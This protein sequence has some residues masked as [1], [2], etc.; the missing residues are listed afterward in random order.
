MVLSDVE[1]VD[2][3]ACPYRMARRFNIEQASA[4]LPELMQGREEILIGRHGEAEVRLVPV[5]IK[6]A[7]RV[8][9]E[10]G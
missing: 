8:K 5:S 7:E 10:R 3:D 4:Q 9:S 1:D 2:G 6:H